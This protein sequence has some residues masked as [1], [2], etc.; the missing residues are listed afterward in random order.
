MFGF[1]ASVPPAVVSW[2]CRRLVCRPSCSAA[3]AARRC[4]L[5]P[6]SHRRFTAVAGLSQ[7]SRRRTC[8]PCAFHRDPC[9]SFVGKSVGKCVARL[10]PYRCT[11][12]AVRVRS[13]SRR[14]VCRKL[15]P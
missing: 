7:Q 5:W 13:V 4:L 14:P 3:C 12:C 10:D 8:G 2:L 6:L 15:C 11:R 9:Q 1:A